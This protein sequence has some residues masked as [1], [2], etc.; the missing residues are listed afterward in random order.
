MSI[1]GHTRTDLRLTRAPADTP[2]GRLHQAAMI[3]ARATRRAATLIPNDAAELQDLAQRGMKLL[4]HDTSRPT[5]LIVRV[6]QGLDQA[7]TALAPLSEVDVPALC[8]ELTGTLVQLE[9]REEQIAGLLRKMRDLEQEVAIK[10]ALNE[11][12]RASL[13]AEQLRNEQLSNL[14][15]DRFDEPTRNSNLTLEDMAALDS[16]GGGTVHGLGTPPRKPAA[17]AR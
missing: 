11:Q 14:L 4:Q 5:R 7:L 15:Q 9:A 1:K 10:G 8:E 6:C 2:R 12:L 17:G 13:A 16:L 3:G